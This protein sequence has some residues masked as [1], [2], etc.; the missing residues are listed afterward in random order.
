MIILIELSYRSIE[1]NAKTQDAA[2]CDTLVTYQ[3]AFDGTCNFVG[4]NF[5]GLLNDTLNA[6][7]AMDENQNLDF[8]IRKLFS[9]YS[10]YFTD[11]YSES[12][13]DHVQKLNGNYF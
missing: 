3:K 2:S 11:R 8:L 1:I 7:Y 9:N 13:S 12:N 10:N 5:A 4:D 6:I